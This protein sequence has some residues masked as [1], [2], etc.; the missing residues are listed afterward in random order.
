MGAYELTPGMT[1]DNLDVSNLSIIYGNL[2]TG[3]SG[4]T[5][6]G[7]CGGVKGQ[8]LKMQMQRHL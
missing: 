1:Y 7:L 5:I 2:T 6:K 4:I 3:T 8:L